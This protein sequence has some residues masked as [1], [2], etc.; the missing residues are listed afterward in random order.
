MSNTSAAARHLDI[1]RNDS[2]TD[3][4]T[5]LLLEQ[6]AERGDRPAIREK[7]RGIWLTTRWRDLADE[8]AALAAA[9]SKRTLQRGTHVAFL[10]DNR[11]RLYAAMCATHWLG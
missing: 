2:A 4:L 1:S 9:L 6:T 5:K 11:P 3:T 10:G 7:R 8:A